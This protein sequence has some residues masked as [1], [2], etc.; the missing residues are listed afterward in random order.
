MTGMDLK[1]T[2]PT[3]YMNVFFHMKQHIQNIAMMAAKTNMTPPGM[4]QKTT[5]IGAEQ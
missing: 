4:P 1:R 5:Q 3:G 2:N